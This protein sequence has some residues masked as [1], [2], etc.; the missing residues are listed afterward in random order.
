MALSGTASRTAPP[1]TGCATYRRST[2]RVWLRRTSIPVRPASAAWNSGR[3]A[4]FSMFSA[5]ASLSASTR[6]WLSI[7]VARA[8]AASAMPFTACFRSP[9][10]SGTAETRNPNIAVFCS[11][12]LSICCRR[13][14]SQVLVI[15]MSRVRVAAAITSVKTNTSLKKIRLFTS[16]PQTCIPRREPCA[17]NAAP[18]GLSRSFPGCAA[19]TRPPSAESR[20]PCP[21][22][23]RRAVDRG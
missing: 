12:L 15:A 6:P 20:T 1:G 14:L 2:P 19:H 22:T 21:A 9:A 10:E 5:T 23:R 13:D 17:G 3:R 8:P 11:K 4:W 18:R 16:G 7:T